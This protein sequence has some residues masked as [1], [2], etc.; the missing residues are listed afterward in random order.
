[1]YDWVIANQNGHFAIEGYDSCT[2]DESKM[3]TTIV[4]YK[5]ATSKGDENV[6]KESVYN[7]G[8]VTVAV[9]GS[10]NSF[11]LYTSGVYSESGCSQTDLDHFMLLVGYGVSGST[12]YWIL[13][14]T[15]G[16]TWG[17]DGYMW[18]ARNQGNMCGVATDTIVPVDQT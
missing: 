2:Y 15:W 14:N 5:A 9:D 10:H 7:D 1:V 12:P 11:Q 3:A 8:V 4:S 18:M 16:T 17:M 6:L 13:Q